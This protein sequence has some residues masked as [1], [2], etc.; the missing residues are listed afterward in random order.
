MPCLS[1]LGWLGFGRLMRETGVIGPLALCALLLVADA[2][3]LVGFIDI[4]PEFEDVWNAIRDLL[5]FV[6]DD[7]AA[8]G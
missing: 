4:V 5:P 6:S 7:P 2:M 1:S 8:I 3:L